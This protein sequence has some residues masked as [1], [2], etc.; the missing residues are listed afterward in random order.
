MSPS[1]VPILVVIRDPA[2]QRRLLRQLRLMGHPA[3]GVSH[4]C[5]G[6]VVLQLRSFELV[7]IDNDMGSPAVLT[8][9]SL[10]QGMMQTVPRIRI[11]HS[12]DP[13]VMP[14]ELSSDEL[15][16][17]IQDH[18]DSRG[19]GS[20]LPR[21]PLRVRVVNKLLS[22]IESS[23]I[24]T[25]A[26]ARRAAN[27]SALTC[28]TLGLSLSECQKG[29]VSAMLRNTGQA[30]LQGVNPEDVSLDHT[31]AAREVM[32]AVP[33]LLPLR[34]PILCFRERWD[35]SGTPSGWNGEDIPV[36][37]RVIAGIDHYEETVRSGLS[38]EHAIQ[39]L[40]DLAGVAFDPKIVEAIKSASK[41]EHW[42]REMATA[43][44]NQSIESVA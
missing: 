21:K 1:D 12:D 26:S 15:G 25:E 13:T 34:D 28:R 44:V 37:A 18:V 38:H 6:S 33:S 42:N 11:G 10:G 29:A 27:R 19:S 8:Q 22:F 20:L 4:A 24:E 7:I 3:I 17:W 9:P 31:I 30:A 35:G 32:N 14:M 36:L 16:E 23:G 40:E 43:S 5:V 41:L 39:R 2:S